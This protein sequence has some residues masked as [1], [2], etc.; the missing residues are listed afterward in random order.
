[1]TSPPP[2]PLSFDEESKIYVIWWNGAEL[3]FEIEN[4]K[5]K[6]TKGS[7]SLVFLV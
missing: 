4:Q 5:Q 7:Q 1:M 3:M 6:V 2:P